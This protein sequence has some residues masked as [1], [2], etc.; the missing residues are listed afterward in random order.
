MSERK[1]NPN[2]PI[3]KRAQTTTKKSVTIY[4]TIVD[5]KSTE[6]VL[7]YKGPVQTTVGYRYN[8]TPPGYKAMWSIL[9][10]F[11]GPVPTTRRA[12][13]STLP[14]P[15]ASP[16][17]R[18]QFCNSGR[19]DA[20]LHFQEKTWAFQGNFHLRTKKKDKIENANSKYFDVLYFETNLYN[21]KTPDMCQVWQNSQTFNDN[22][23]FKQLLNQLTIKCYYIV[24]ISRS[25]SAKYDLS[26]NKIPHN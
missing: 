20:M 8:Y 9:I 21:A 14:P 3:N 24:E 7:L 18:R 13:P 6:D 12:L 17:L 26:G 5:K 15:T 23:Y 22:S 1:K 19:V 10:S 4:L 11:S 16:D 25:D 2:K